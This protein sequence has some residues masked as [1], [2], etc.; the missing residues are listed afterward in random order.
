[1]KRCNF[2]SRKLS[3]GEA[4]GREGGREKGREKKCLPAVSEV[5]N[6]FS[7]V[8]ELFCIVCR[9]RGYACERWLLAASNQKKKMNCI[10][11]IL[12][13][14]LL[15]TTVDTPPTHKYISPGSLR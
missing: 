10:E 5:G 13:H 14:T 1:M 11:L 12:L 15:V 4:G 8:W 9:L 7:D 6:R 3:G 2:S